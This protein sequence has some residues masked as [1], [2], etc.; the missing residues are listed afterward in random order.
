MSHQAEAT[1]TPSGRISQRID[2]LTD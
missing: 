2:G 1:M